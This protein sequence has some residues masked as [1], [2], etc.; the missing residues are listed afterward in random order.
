[1]SIF[2]LFSC[3]S[4]QYLMLLILPPS[5]NFSLPLCSGFHDTTLSCLPPSSLAGL[6][7]VCFPVSPFYHGLFN[8]TVD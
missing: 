3:W 8:T 6:F 1:M 5:G 2:Q 7:C 4:L